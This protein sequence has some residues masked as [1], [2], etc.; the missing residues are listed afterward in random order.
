M[1]KKPCNPELIKNDRYEL[2]QEYYRW[3]NSS[4]IKLNIRTSFML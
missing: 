3:G 1:D 2:R 4:G